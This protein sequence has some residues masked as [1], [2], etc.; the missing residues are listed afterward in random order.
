MA[1]IDE[2]L[3]E[4]APEI[5]DLKGVLYFKLGQNHLSYKCDLTSTLSSKLFS[6]PFTAV[7]P[8][9]GTLQNFVTD[10]HASLAALVPRSEPFPSGVTPSE[11]EN[12]VAE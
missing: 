5:V 10:R 9:S 8:P 12:F 11:W 4:L 2:K 7:L 6:V 3:C 1:Q